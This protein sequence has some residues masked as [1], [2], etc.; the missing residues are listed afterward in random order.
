MNT[1]I[2][3][4]SS[5]TVH[6][7]ASMANRINELE[8]A[9]QALQRQLDETRGHLLQANKMSLVGQM[10][11]TVAHDLNNPLNGVLGFT[12][13]MRRR[14]TDQN[15]QR[16][17]QRIETEARRAAKIVQSLLTFVRDHKPER[18]P[19]NLNDVVRSMTELHAHHRMINEVELTLDLDPRLPETIADPHQ[20]GQAILNLITNAEQA[21]IDAALRGSIH[22]STSLFREEGRKVILLTVRD[23]G[24]GIPSDMLNRIFEPF[25]TTKPAGEGTGLGLYIC[26]QIIQDHQGDLM[27]DSQM[28][29]GTAFTITLPLVGGAADTAADLEEERVVPVEM[30]PAHGLVIDDEQTV[31]EFVAEALVSL[32]HEMDMA[33]NGREAFE[34]LKKNQYDFIVCDLKMPEVNGQ[35]F[36]DVVK[37]FDERLS[38]RIIFITGDTANLNTE[39]FFEETDNFYLYKPFQLDDLI[40]VVRAVVMKKTQ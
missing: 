38:R 32:G 27:V 6:Q 19:V 35:T 5:T 26:R 24:P 28:G 29:I 8:A 25:F 33:A 3:Q 15:M 21:I 22:I 16:G 1:R 10:V 9:C 12:E 37:S 13:L 2:E 14:T 7:A 20:L 31:R 18:Q 39:R 30:P 4:H 23:T 36:Y 17:L 11:A 34:A 40:E